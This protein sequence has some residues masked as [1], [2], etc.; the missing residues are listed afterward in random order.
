MNTLDQVLQKLG[1]EKSRLLVKVSDSGWKDLVP[2]RLQK[3][4]EEIKPDR[5]YLQNEKPLILFFKF[6]EKEDGKEK[7][8]YEIV[9]SKEA[10]MQQRKISHL[11]PLGEALIGKKKNDTFYFDTPN[12][13]MKC[14]VIDVK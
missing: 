1:I 6:D 4:L 12:G 10:D 14:K 5:I 7:H 13:K 9:G 8:Q 11:S 2:Y 3:G